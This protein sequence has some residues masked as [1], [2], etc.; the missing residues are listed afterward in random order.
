[1]KEKKKKRLCRAVAPS[2]LPVFSASLRLLTGFGDGGLAK[3]GGIAGDKGGGVQVVDHGHGPAAVAQTS[4]P[5]IGAPIL[6]GH[7]GQAQAGLRRDQLIAAGDPCLVLPAIAA[8]NIHA[9]AHILV[10]VQ[11]HVGV[12]VGNGLVVV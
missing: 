4:P 3:T 2:L 5:D 9:R 7:C 8:P 10:D 6:V 12:Q 1:M 11:A